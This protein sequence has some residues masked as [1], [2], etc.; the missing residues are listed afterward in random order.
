MGDSMRAPPPRPSPPTP[1]LEDP[2]PSPLRILTAMQRLSQYV[3]YAVKAK[4]RLTV[5]YCMYLVCTRTMVC[6]GSPARSTYGMTR[7]LWPR[8]LQCCI[9][10][11][12]GRSLT[13][14][15]R[16]TR[17]PAQDWAGRAATPCLREWSAS[18]R[19]VH[20]WSLRQGEM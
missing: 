4:T 1:A 13:C 11:R 16:Y 19:A 14:Y 10:G 20:R 6:T 12:V 15:S 3:E 9:R 17:A 7:E 18:L 5:P 8:I 2:L